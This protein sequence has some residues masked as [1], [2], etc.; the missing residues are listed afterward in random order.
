MKQDFLN[1]VYFWDSLQM[2]QV[3][4]RHFYEIATHFSGIWVTIFL[5][6]AETFLANMS[7]L[8]SRLR[9]PE[10]LINSHILDIS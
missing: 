6:A 4:V 5:A 10:S 7:F 3:K 9:D 2:V 8:A 1:F